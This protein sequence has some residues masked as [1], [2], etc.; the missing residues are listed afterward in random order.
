MSA[1]VIDLPER[2]KVKRLPHTL[3]FFALSAK[4][5]I[6]RRAELR[7]EGL[8]EAGEA[9]ALDALLAA[10]E[11]LVERACDPDFL[12]FL[13]GALEQALELARK[14]SQR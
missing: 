2:A 12:D 4:R 13:N 6:Q 3:C 9:M 8:S 5:V 7:A 11:D 1:Q 10:E 14:G